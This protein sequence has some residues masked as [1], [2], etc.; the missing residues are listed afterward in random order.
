MFNDV[1]I[2]ALATHCFP[3]DL[4]ILYLLFFLT[5]KVTCLPAGRQKSQGKSECSAGFA[6]AHAQP[7]ELLHRV[8]LMYSYFP[9]ACFVTLVN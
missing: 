7:A 5:K 4:N 1:T 3:H 8:S 2:A 9:I 6:I